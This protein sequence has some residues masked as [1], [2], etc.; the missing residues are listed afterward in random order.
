MMVRPQGIE[1]VLCN[2]EGT[3]HALERRCG[4]M[5]APLEMGTLNQGILTCPMHSAQFSIMTGEVINDALRRNR[6]PAK[7]D[8]LVAVH[9]YIT[10]LIEKVTTM[11]VKTYPVTIEGDD[12]FVEV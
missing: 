9:E 12:V 11:D 3:Y 10:M 4:H 5:N 7:K 8:G 6:T 1:I 2:H